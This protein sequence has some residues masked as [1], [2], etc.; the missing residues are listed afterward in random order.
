V[1][2]PYLCDDYDYGCDNGYYDNDYYYNYNNSDCWVS[3]RVYDQKGNFV[4]WRQ[5]YICQDGQ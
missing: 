2:G 1:I 3:R 4:A 5:V